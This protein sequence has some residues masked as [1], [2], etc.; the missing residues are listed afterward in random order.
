MIA[1]AEQAVPSIPHCLH[2]DSTRIRPADVLARVVHQVQQ[3][4][5]DRRR[6]GLYAKLPSILRNAVSVNVL[7]R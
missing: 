2:V 6:I 4:L 7:P 3:N 1:H 5:L